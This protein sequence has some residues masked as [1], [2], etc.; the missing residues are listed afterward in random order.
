MAYLESR[1]LLCLLAVLLLHK[2]PFV[3]YNIIK[4]SRFHTVLSSP[5]VIIIT[6][7]IIAK[8]VDPIM[9]AIASGYVMKSRLGPEIKITTGARHRL[10]YVESADLI[11]TSVFSDLYLWPH[12]QPRPSSSLPCSPA[13]WRL[14]SL[15]QSWSGSSPNWSQWHHCWRK[16][17]TEIHSCHCKCLKVK[18]KL[19][20][21][22]KIMFQHYLKTC[23]I[24]HL[25]VKLS[26]LVNH[27]LLWHLIG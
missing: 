19:E 13:Q 23:T 7:K 5:S 24:I 11:L 3:Y 12:P 20:K 21:K 1:L 6:K 26:Y 22:I 18:I 17:T 2:W 8:K 4:L 25:N 27:I 9:F 10:V 14:Q 15:T 16:N